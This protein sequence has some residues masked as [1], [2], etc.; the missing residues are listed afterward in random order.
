[1]NWISS[2]NK[3]HRS[4]SP[5]HNF[6]W[7][8]NILYLYRVFLIVSSVCYIDFFKILFVHSFT[9]VE[10][11]YS[12]ESFLLT[13]CFATEFSC[14]LPSHHV[15]VAGGRAPVDRHHS[16]AFLPTE[17][18]CSLDSISTVSGLTVNMNNLVTKWQSSEIKKQRAT[19]F[20]INENTI[21]F[22]KCIIM[23]MKNAFG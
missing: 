11:F 6:K 7:E 17:S 5:R 8:S 9:I 18:G 3:M 10:I 16:S 21:I 19:S 4:I 20:T 12:Y 15:M 1:M 13:R 22:Y 23:K 2:R 14:L